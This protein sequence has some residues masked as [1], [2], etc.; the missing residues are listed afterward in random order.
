MTRSVLTPFGESVST[1]P[2]LDVFVLA[3]V[4]R[5]LREKVRNLTGEPRERWKQN[6][7]DAAKTYAECLEANG[8]K[9]VSKRELGFSDPGMSYPGGLS[10]NE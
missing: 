10:L 4:W 8:V 2:P 5:A 1:D 9:A 3:L 7:Q 6:L